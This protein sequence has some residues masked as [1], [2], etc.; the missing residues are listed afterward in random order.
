MAGRAVEHVVREEE[1]GYAVLSVQPLDLL[2]NPL[3]RAQPHPA[4]RQ[5]RVGAV[6][7]VQRT[8]TFGLNTDPARPLVDGQVEEIKSRHAH[9]IE[10]QELPRPG[11]EDL[12]I[13]PVV[14]A[15]HRLGMVQM[16][17][18]LRQSLL[19]LQ[20]HAVVDL[21]KP[22]HDRFGEEREARPAGDDGGF[23]AALSSAPD[24]SLE[25]GPVGEEVIRLGRVDV[26]QRKA[27]DVGL[28]A[29]GNLGQPSPRIVYSRGIE[30]GHL[31]PPQRASHVSQAQ[32]EDRR[33]G[34]PQRGIRQQ[35]LHR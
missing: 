8:T 21:W 30:A 4:P 14:Q 29:C 35:D 27:D 25:A 20:V 13:T 28:G 34:P 32:R 5:E 16:L 7:A 1:L 11:E 26:A 19:A 2:A 10:I 6:H 24:T 17:E 31:V 23:G 12:A 15:P 18:K 9:G 3:R 33:L 22:C